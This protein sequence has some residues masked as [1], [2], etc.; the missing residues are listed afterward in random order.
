MGVLNINQQDSNNKSIEKTLLSVSNLYINEKDNTY[1]NHTCTSN[2]LDGTGNAL[3][4]GISKGTN[5]QRAGE[6][7]KRILPRNERRAGTTRY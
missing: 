7:D 6:R 2:K 3:V 1:D 5:V 4:Y